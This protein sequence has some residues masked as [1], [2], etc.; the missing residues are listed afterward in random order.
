MSRLIHLPALALSLLTAAPALAA[1]KVKCDSCESCTAAL[2]AEGARVELTADLAASGPT[3]V[4]LAGAG[5]ELNGGEHSLQ[6]EGTGVLITGAGA[7]L[8]RLSVSGG[9]IGVE[10]KGAA[11]VTLMAV[12]VKGA[13][14][15]ISADGAESL[16]VVRSS[17]EGG[18]VG[19]SYGAKKGGQCAPGAKMRS[20]GAVISRSSFTGAKVGVAACE[21][22][23]VIVGAKITGNG[24]GLLTAAPKASGKG[25]G[26]KG[27][28]D[29]CVCG[30]EL[31]GV[32]QETTMFFSSGCGGCKVH[33]G[34]L[35]EV[36]QQGYDIL[37]RP[38]GAENRQAMD[39]FDRFLRQCAPEVNDAIGIPGCV[40]N[41][42]CLPGQFVFKRRET[43]KLLARDAQIQGPEGMAEFSAR[44][45]AAAQAHYNP[46][47]ACVR[48]AVR[49]SEICGNT[50]DAQ[51][52]GP[53]SGEGNTCGL[54][55]KLGCAQPCGAR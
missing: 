55:E 36:Q 3:C 4:T 49:E 31:P 45:V 40:P 5:A 32:K 54:G 13:Q 12:S 16:R 9:E 6:S 17:T 14:V 15:G 37:L 23:P 52:A 51:L 27:P 48:H 30:P 50:V 22:S 26:Q 8:R 39:R 29:P 35:P 1:P 34:W 28:Y 21:A 25:P 44:C 46:T 18:Q 33:E 7:H 20:P 19:L 47:G 10:V 41:Y 2:A 43:G 11:Q 53:L 42:A 38:T 24:T